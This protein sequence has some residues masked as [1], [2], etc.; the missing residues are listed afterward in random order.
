MQNSETEPF[1][2]NIKRLSSKNTFRAAARAFFAPMQ[3]RG[4]RHF[5]QKSGIITATPAF[6]APGTAF[7]RKNRKTA[8][9]EIS[10]LRSK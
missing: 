8:L 6:Q 9:E 4:T 3:P 7:F 10:R 2:K 1:Y 5:T